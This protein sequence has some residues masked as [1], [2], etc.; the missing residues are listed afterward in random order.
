MIQWA[1]RSALSC[2]HLET[3]VGGINGNRD[4][5]HGTHGSLEVGLALFLDVPV[6]RHCGTAV[7]LLVLTLLLILEP[8][9]EL[10]GEEAT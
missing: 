10:M 8:S 6:A 4:R 9:I 2:P 7:C 5:S 1:D 3:T